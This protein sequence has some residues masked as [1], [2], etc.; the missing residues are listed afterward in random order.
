[1]GIFSRAKDRLIEQM[2]LG[3]LNGHLLL[4]YGKATHLRIDSELKRISIDAQLKGE[5]TPITIDLVDYE[6]SKKGDNYFAEVR[7]IETS[8]E[9]LSTL[10]A[11]ELVPVKLK[12]PPAVGRLL[13]HA[14]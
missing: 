12:L 6:V 10:A 8:R 2:A 4:P 7:K 11:N 13:F 5:A 3:Y 1:M 14:L 9:W